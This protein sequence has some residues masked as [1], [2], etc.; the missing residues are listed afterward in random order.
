[1]T[2]NLVAVSIVVLFLG[3]VIAPSI[4]G[5]FLRTWKKVEK[6]GTTEEAKLVEVTCGF[7][8]LSGVKERTKQI[9]FKDALQLSRLMN[10]YRSVLPRHGGNMDYLFLDNLVTELRELKLI[11]SSFNDQLVKELINGQYGKKA[12]HKYFRG[13]K[14]EENISPTLEVEKKWMINIGCLISSSGEGGV[15]FPTDVFFYLAGFF[16]TFVLE[17]LGFLCDMLSFISWGC[18]RILIP[19]NIV[20]LTP[21]YGGHNAV[22]GSLGLLGYQHLSGD[23]VKL[24]LG[25]FV[26]MYLQ[27]PI[28]ENIECSIAGFA[29]VAIAVAS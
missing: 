21:L 18:P 14:V 27:F 25:G 4:N 28:G 3:M 23:Y 26:G 16:Y 29:P 7:S 10:E 17:R 11:P 12:Y 24:F 1:M 20:E 9:P 15:K 8:V 19:F 13:K 2:K 6:T 5:Q 22:V